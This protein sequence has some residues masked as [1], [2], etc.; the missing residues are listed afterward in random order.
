[1]LPFRDVHFCLALVAGGDVAAA[2]RQISSM[3]AFSAQNDGWTAEV[4][5][6]TLIALCEGLI[7]YAE[8]DHAKACDLLWPMRNE[9]ALI[10]GSH[11]QRD[12]VIDTYIAALEG[13]GQQEAARDIALERAAQ[14]AS[15]LDE[16]WFAQLVC[17]A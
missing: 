1:M 12:L 11:A 14:R 10:G 17:S 9:L 3:E 4:T 2:Q 7:A 6:S 16:R 15:H 13:E 8:G 5:G